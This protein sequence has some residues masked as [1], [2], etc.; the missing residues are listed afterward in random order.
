MAERFLIAG[1]EEIIHACEAVHRWQRV[2]APDAVTNP[3]TPATGQPAR[4]PWHGVV[5]KGFDGEPC[6]VNLPQSVPESMAVGLAEFSPPAV[7]TS[8]RG[9]RQA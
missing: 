2:E 6:P 9:R 1:L 8:V 5:A 4:K 3:Q 7:D